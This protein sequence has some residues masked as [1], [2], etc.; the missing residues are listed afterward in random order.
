MNR[1]QVTLDDIVRRNISAHHDAYY[2]WL[3]YVVTLASGS[4]T[5]LVA[6]KSNYVPNNPQG[7]WLLQLCWMV[8]V[9]SILGG[10]LALHGEYRTPLDLAAEIRKNQAEHGDHYT[11]KMLDDSLATSPRKLFLIAGKSVFP[12]Y[13]LSLVLL[14]AFAALNLQAE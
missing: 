13:A 6:L 8:L 2:S 5:L 9:L 4:L 12:L 14:V 10:V 7:L 3:R 11:E 1:K